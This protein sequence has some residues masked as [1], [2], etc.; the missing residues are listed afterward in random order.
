[1]LVSMAGGAW[2]GGEEAFIDVTDFLMNKA[3]NGVAINGILTWIDIQQK[4]TAPIFWQA[5][6]DENFTDEEVM[7]AKKA[8][9]KACGTKLEI[10]GPIVNRTADRKKTTIDKFGKAMIKLKEYNVLPLLL[11]SSDM[12]KRAPYFN[13]CPSTA[14]ASD[15]LARVKV[16]EDSMGSYMKQQTQEMS[17]LSHAVGSLAPQPQP[18]SRIRLESVGKKHKL[19]DEVEVFDDTRDNVNWPLPQTKIKTFASIA[20]GDSNAKSGNTNGQIGNNNP[21]SRRPST[22]LF[23]KAKVG[24]DDIENILA[25][26][27]N[28]VA[29]G[30]A[31]DATAIQLKEFIVAKG[32][33]VVE[34]E[35][36][37]QQ[38]SKFLVKSVWSAKWK[39]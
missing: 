26:N 34:I 17:R 33:E 32:I 5:Q 10:I 39:Y 36:L 4:E 6:A 12:M 1:M 9:W 14:N 13:T 20:R 3:K 22:L 18:I 23:G 2:G 31:K 15:V 11:G 24:K 7:D 38:N 27:V 37:T 19:D 30:V 35:L 8:L 28:L 25:A 29:T 21:R 16:L